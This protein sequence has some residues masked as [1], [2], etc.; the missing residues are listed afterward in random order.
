MIDLDPQSCLQ[1]IRQVLISDYGVATDSVELLAL[2]SEA[3]TYAAR[4]GATRYFVKLHDPDGLGEL[5][6]TLRLTYFL[7]KEGGIESVLP[8]L[9]TSSG[10]LRASFGPYPI[11]VHPFIRGQSA[12][13]RGPLTEN[14]T[15]RIGR[16]VGDIHHAT[17]TP[18]FTAGL[19]EH[20]DTGCIEVIGRLLARTSGV[21]RTSG[22]VLSLLDQNR[23]LLCQATDELRRLRDRV[24]FGPI[25]YAIT[26][27]DLT[28]GNFMLD[29]DGHFHVVDW[30]S[31]LLA[32][33]E[34]DLVFFSEAGAEAFLS[35]YART[36]TL[37]HVNIDMLSFF[38]Y[39]WC[40]DGIA[41][42]ANRILTEQDTSVR[43]EDDLGVL[44]TFL[45]FDAKK[46]ADSMSSMERIIRTLAPRT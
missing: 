14:E 22:R 24:R 42:F 46:I 7:N 3:Y 44:H 13:A 34:R 18:E 23:E 12:A 6:F 25:R 2:G 15:M 27:G 1:D 36:A 31:A 19:I 21:G 43:T 29:E 45:P 32:P 16:L 4:A 35:G 10:A 28:L 9:A 38:A 30:N 5:D 37:E 33:V 8:P 11:T 40:L 39:R 20:F 17:V 26:H 41:F